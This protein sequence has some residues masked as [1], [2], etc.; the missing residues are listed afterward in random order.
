MQ[1]LRFLVMLGVFCIGCLF[2][3]RFVFGQNGQ[4]SVE[5]RVIVRT[6]SPEEVQKAL[7][8]GMQVDIR[9]DI[10]RTPLMWAAFSNENPEVLKMLLD[11]GARVDARDEAGRTPL[12]RAASHNENPEIARVLLAAG[13]NVH[14]R[15]ERGRTALMRGAQWNRN[16][17]VIK[18]LLEAGADKKARCYYGKTAFEYAQGNEHMHETEV[19]RF[20]KEAG[21]FSIDRI[22]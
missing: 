18:V 1:R 19:Y 8:T 15:D 5:L 9:D 22:T 21:I 2:C 3:T 7:E 12:M 6:G 17:E 20:L 10:G 13:A 16:P 11:A 4:Q 14:A